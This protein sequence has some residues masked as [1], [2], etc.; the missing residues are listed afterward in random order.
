M[1]KP[2]AT[3]WTDSAVAWPALPLDAWKDTCD[4]IHMW[5]QIVGKI[6]LGLAAPINHWWHCTFYLTSRGLTTSAIPHGSGTFEMRFDFLGHELV[7]DVSDGAT[8][9]L[10]LAPRSVA[11]FYGDLMTTLLGLGISVRISPMPNE[12]PDPIPFPEDTQHASYDREYATRFWRIL[13]SADTVLKEFRGRFIGKCSPVHFFWGSFD[14]AVSRF[15]GRLAPPIEHAEAIT[16]EGYS[17][18]VSSVGF[19]PGSGNVREPAF[20][21]YTAPAPPG[22]ERAA[23]QP[24]G[25]IYHSDLGEFLFPYE[26]M[27]ETRSPR[28]SLLAFAQS[29]YEAGANLA[30]WDRAALER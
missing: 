22:L 8:R 9:R 13:A 15:S 1:T 10:R 17:H 14:L 7:I 12:V 26:R 3:S 30:H 23:V 5:T 19:W 24:A 18:E 20:Y 21:A 29:T 28:A 27:R 16:R 2:E 25:A 4:T 11:D 6:R